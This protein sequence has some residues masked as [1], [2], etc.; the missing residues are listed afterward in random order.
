MEVPRANRWFSTIQGVAL[1][2]AT[3]V[4]F[5]IFAQFG[6]LHLVQAREPSGNAVRTIMG[7]M[8]LAGLLG[9][10]ATFRIV[11]IDNLRNLLLASFLGCGGAAVLALI[12]RN[13]LSLMAVSALVG[14]CLALLTVCLTAS[15]PHLFSNSDRGAA[16][17]LGTGVAYA[18]CNIPAVFAGTAARQ[19]WVAV[20][21][22]VLGAVATIIRPF[23]S[24]IEA[25]R[26][27]ETHTT[28]PSFAPLIGIFLALVWLDSS[29]FLILQSTPSLNQF[30]WGTAALQWS[31]AGIHLLL[32]LLAGYWLDRGALMQVLVLAFVCLATAATLASA[33]NAIAHLTH[34]LYA[35]GVSLY[36]TAL[37]FAP[38][39]RASRADSVAV[40]RRAGALYGIA[41][42]CGSALGIGM[43]QDL[44]TIPKWFICSAGGFFA[45]Q[46]LWYRRLTLQA[47]L[48][49]SASAVALGGLAIIVSNQW[50]S[51]RTGANF[52]QTQLPDA[53]F[54][55]EVYISEGCIHCHSQYVRPAA[56]E[57]G[58]WWGPAAKP[59]L[60]LQ[61]QP[62]LIGNRRQGPDLLNIGNRRSGAWNR[63][64]LIDPRAVVPNSR[65]PSYAYL[66]RQDDPRGEA[67]VAYLSTM[68]AETLAWRLAAR[69]E[70]QPALDI[71][72][73]SSDQ[74][75]LLFA[76]NCSAC[77]G[78]FGAGDG[79]LARSLGERGPRDL[80]KAQWQF[81]PRRNKQEQRLLE[82]AR[83]IKF[84]VPTTSMPGHETMSDDELLGLARYVES[85][86]F[87][88][89]SL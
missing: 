41:G 54:G 74:A 71:Q 62:P 89:H 51:A 12:A 28:T 1:T 78:P 85:L 25:A 24:E 5:L 23:P 42:W 88:V 43:A 27:V 2:S 44:H 52:E 47:L 81:I 46:W 11:R 21:V 45:I 26:K 67:L 48:H 60:A 53:S 22:C 59:D 4:Y 73:I 16:V 30:G 3:Y 87:P 6:F 80:T 50:A 14:V 86:Q 79:R 7:A 38:M 83:V 77:H 75:A 31:N 49:S 82:L 55:R 69:Q 68:G 64:H 39:E 40:A 36:S 63:I 10:L 17:G 61:D 13:T 9:S 84:G 32:A 70:W 8:A 34:W 18:I 76:A 19:S 15:L 65:M 56:R 29:A 37:V 58:D 72:P 33:D 35:G 57:E 20:A 66:F